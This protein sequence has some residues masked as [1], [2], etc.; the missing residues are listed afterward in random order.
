MSLII[1]LCDVS[2]EL[3]LHEE[4]FQQRTGGIDFVLEKLSKS[5]T[6]TKKEH[7]EKGWTVIRYVKTL[8]KEGPSDVCRTPFLVWIKQTKT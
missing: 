5:F 6:R 4:S 8:L 2:V 7:R 3:N 1:E